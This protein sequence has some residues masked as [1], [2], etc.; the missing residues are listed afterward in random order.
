MQGETSFAAPRATV[1]EVLNDPAR[2][3]KTMPNVESFDVLDDRRW[4][5]NVAVPLGLGSLKLAINFDKT[6]ERP[7]EFARLSAKGQGVGA[8][9]NMDTQFELAESA[10]GTDMRWEA[11]VRIAGPV[12]AMG[13]RVIQPIVNQQVKQVLAALGEQVQQAAGAGSDPAASLPPP[14][15]DVPRLETPSGGAFV[16]AAA[17]QTQPQDGFT[18]GPAG[19]PREVRMD[20]EPETDPDLKDYGPPAESTPEADPASVEGSSGA[21]EGI[22]PW[23]PESYSDE[24]EGPTTSTEER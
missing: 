7:P 23:A 6:E 21:E 4:K 15:D 2:M 16:E 1:W 10:A 24:P 12:G 11:E 14:Q 8:L 9:L 5:A 18:G 20:V 13:Q 22:N 17:T 3:A 19:G